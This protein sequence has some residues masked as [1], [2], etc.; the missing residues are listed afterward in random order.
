MAPDPY[1]NFKFRVKWDGTYVAGVS[2]VSAL[3][4]AQGMKSLSD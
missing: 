3:G 2:K 1:L 4:F